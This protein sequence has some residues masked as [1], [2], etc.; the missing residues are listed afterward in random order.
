MTVTHQQISIIKFK[1]NIDNKIEALPNMKWKGCSCLLWM[2]SKKNNNNGLGGEALYFR[3]VNDE[4]RTFDYCINNCSTH[5]WLVLC[6]R[7]VVGNWLKTTTGKWITNSKNK[8]LLHQW[9]SYLPQLAAESI[10]AF[11]LVVG[12]I[13]RN[14]HGLRL[15]IQTCVCF[16]VWHMKHVF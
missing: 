3:T 9:P 13:Y 16:I 10:P 4:S 5:Y 15:G 2:A 12:T 1:Q 6:S 11:L 7:L 8:K 14:R